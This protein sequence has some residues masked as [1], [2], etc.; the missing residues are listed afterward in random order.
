MEQVELNNMCI[1]RG[2]NKGSEE[3]WT[4]KSTLI[5]GKQIKSVHASYFYV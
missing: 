5:S 3:L 4:I 1:N 2:A